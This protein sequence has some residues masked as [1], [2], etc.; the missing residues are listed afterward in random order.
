[1]NEG[2]KIT[3]VEAEA[4]LNN[5][6]V[7]I[8]PTDTLYGV[9]AKA[10][11]IEAVH[12]VDKLK[13]RSHVKSYI[14]LISDISELELF[15]IQINPRIK[16]FLSRVWPGPVTVALSVDEGVFPFLREGHNSIAF[17]LPKS[18]K[19]IELIKNT[20]P[21]VAPSANPEGL[22]PASSIEDAQK[23]FGA[24]AS[25]YIDGGIRTGMP[26]TVISFEKGDL[27]CVREGALPF[28]WIKEIW[29]QTK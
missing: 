27:E 16:T 15:W 24:D 9:L 12:K 8:A 13:G 28:E 17:R 4:I 20:G 10:T 11:D 26:S 3:Y 2:G 19:L 29:E 1:M 25:G 7:V 18:E 21:L 5:G 23:Y 22:T 6:G 14:V